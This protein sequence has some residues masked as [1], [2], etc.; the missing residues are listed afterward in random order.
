MHFTKITLT[1]SVRGHSY[2]DCDRQ[3]ASLNPKAWLETPEAG[4]EHFEAAWRKPSPFV[5]QLITEN[6]QNSDQ[7]VGQNMFRKWTEHLTPLYAKRN[8]PIRPIRE[9][10]TDNTT[11][12]ILYQT[13]YNRVWE[14]VVIVKRNN[15]P[16]QNEEFILRGLSYDGP[17]P[18]SAA[19]YKD[20][21]SLDKFCEPKARIFFEN[22]QHN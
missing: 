13:T 18:I 17:I 10:R 19:K 9:V 22:L 11:E 21:Q 8:F 7:I 15:R 2:L 12:D 5:V 6:E 20:L 3:M 14:R 1:Y 4:K 16:P